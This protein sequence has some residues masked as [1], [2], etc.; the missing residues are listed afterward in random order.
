MC[1]G[2]LQKSN[3]FYVQ[4]SINA[5]FVK[6]L[7]QLDFTISILQRFKKPPRCRC[8]S[9]FSSAAAEKPDG[10]AMQLHLHLGHAVPEHLKAMRPTSTHRKDRQVLAEEVVLQLSV[11]TLWTKAID[12]ATLG[13]EVERH[14]WGTKIVL[15]FCGFTEKNEENVRNLKH[16]A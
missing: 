11:N 14:I 6:H 2:S 3:C 13:A 12:T 9:L 4:I 15:C 5:K 10:W 16:W 7:G 1:I 8:S